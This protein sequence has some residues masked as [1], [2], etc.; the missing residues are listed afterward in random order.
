MFKN[1]D[2][3]SNLSNNIRYARDCYLKLQVLEQLMA[4]NQSKNFYF[5]PC[6][7][8][9]YLFPQQEIFPVSDVQ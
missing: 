2:N 1:L 8:Y 5:L 6:I 9:I 7:S 3:R 4:K